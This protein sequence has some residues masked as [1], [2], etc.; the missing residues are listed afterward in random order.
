MMLSAMPVAQAD[1]D[2]RAPAGFWKCLFYGYEGDAY[3]KEV[4]A[5][6]CDFER[7]ETKFGSV[8]ELKDNVMQDMHYGERYFAARREKNGE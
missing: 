7:P 6:F 2:G 8:E 1:R 5:Q 3:G 4:T